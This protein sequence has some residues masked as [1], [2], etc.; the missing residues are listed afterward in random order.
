MQVFIFRSFGLKMSIQSPKIGVLGEFDPLN[1]EPYE[2]HPQKAILAQN[3]VIWRIDR[4]NRSTGA[5]CTRCL[6]YT[7]DAADE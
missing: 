2:R 7:S 6:L 3:D 5:T 4:H 1:G